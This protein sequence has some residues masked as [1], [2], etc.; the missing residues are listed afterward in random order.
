[1][2]GVVGLVSRSWPAWQELQNHS[3]AEAAWNCTPQRATVPYAK[4]NELL[5]KFLS[6]TAPVKRGLNL[7]GPPSKA[8]YYLVTDSGLVP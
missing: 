7:G 6:R 1:M 4:T 8:K 2:V 5:I 3:L